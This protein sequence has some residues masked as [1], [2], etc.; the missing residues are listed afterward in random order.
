MLDLNDLRIFERV[1]TLRS[2]SGAARV[3]GAPKSTVSRSIARLETALG[4][5]LF[6]RTT[7]DVLLTEAGESLEAR[8]HDIMARVNEAVD[9]ARV[10]S[11]TPQGLLKISAGIGFGINV[12]AE[13]IPV[14]LRRNPE[15]RVSL[16]LCARTADLVS[17]GIDIAVRMG[18][19]PD[20]SLI[21]AHLGTL[22]RYLCAAPAYL[23]RRGTPATLQDLADHDVI[24]MP[25]ANGR[26][27]SWTFSRGKETVVVAIDPRTTVNDALSIHRMAVNGSGL[28][29]ISGYLCAPDVAAGRLVR[30]F[31][32]WSPPAVDVNLVFPSIR[33]LSP[34]V[35]AFV[36]HMRE[37]SG[38]DQL[39][40]TDPLQGPA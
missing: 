12:L 8:C 22:N 37:V 33:E 4:V 31:P 11:E 13:Q 1:A 18:P 26:T 19:M 28:A 5:R 9:H 29:I 15:V 35:R 3:L 6:Q 25:A 7:R 2:F 21:A 38:P 34:V 17:D 20:S 23:D 32:D 40:L 14:F 24:E 27:R 39:W 16:D 36:D 30:L 10:M